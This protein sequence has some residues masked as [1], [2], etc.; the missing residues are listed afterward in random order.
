MSIG[1]ATPGECMRYTVAVVM[2]GLLSAGML[3]A[4]QAGVAPPI[5][6]GRSAQLAAPG[7]RGQ[8]VMRPGQ[9]RM[10]AKRRQGMRQALGLTAEQRQRLQELRQQR[11]PERQAL[12]AKLAAARRAMQEAE[13]A[14]PPSETAI[15]ER[16]EA[17]ARIQGEMAVAR[18]R[19]RQDL[20]S[21]LTPEQRQ[22]ARDVLA[23]QSARQRARGMRVR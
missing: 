16:A 14:D 23:K 22:K 10:G 19:G 13:L 21:V 8:R 18:A 4:S 2:A 20:F 11:Q 17:L 9:R 12:T 6:P 1:G 15:G 5:G 3:E 7:A